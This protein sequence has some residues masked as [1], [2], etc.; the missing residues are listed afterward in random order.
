[1]PDEKDLVIEITPDAPDAVEPEKKPDE[2]V[3]AKKEDLPAIEPVEDLRNQLEA[4]TKD[5]DAQKAERERVSQEN[6]RLAQENTQAKEK[7]AQVEIRAVD[8]DMAAV[9]SA[10]EAAKIEAESASNDW[11]QAQTNGDIAKAK[12]AQRKVARAEAKVLRL[13]EG[14][15][16]IAAR[17]AEMPKQDGGAVRK[18]EQPQQRQAPDDQFER[19]ISA[20]TPRAQKWLREHPEYV[21]DEG[22]NRK[23]NIAHLKAI[24]DGHVMDSDSYFDF[25]ET[26]LGLKK[27]TDEPTPKPAQQTQRTR[28]MPAAPVSRETISMNGSLTP[29]QVSL[30]PGEQRVATD[31]THTWNY[32]DEKLGA[33]KGEPIGL[34]E[35]A[36]RKLAMQKQGAYD[37]S[38]SDQ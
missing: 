32:T 14:R 11:E 27:K 38:Y 15:D 18:T 29:T 20:A 13:E 26:E 4:L 34:K 10:I 8:S 17:K 30:T 35:M 12:E 23:A 28:S 1:M 24:D 16:D 25:C 19:A 21:K 2:K 7:V 31:G 33:K 5:R 36:R 3:E 6:Q 37:R 9:E 22:L